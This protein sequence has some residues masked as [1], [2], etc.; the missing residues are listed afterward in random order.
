MLKRFLLIASISAGLFQIAPAEEAPKLLLPLA[1][2]QAIAGFARSQDGQQLASAD[3]LGGVRVWNSAGQILQTFQ[4]GG[5]SDQPLLS[6]CSKNVLLVQSGQ[7]IVLCNSRSGNV[8]KRFSITGPAVQI[9]GD[10]LWAIDSEGVKCWNVHDGKQVLE[11][12]ASSLGEKRRLKALACDPRSHRVAV[13]GESK[14]YFL[15][16]ATAR[17]VQTLDIP[18]EFAD[19]NWSYDVTRLLFAQNGEGM[20][21]GCE[22][23]WIL[24]RRGDRWKQIQLPAEARIRDLTADGLCLSD[25]GALYR[26]NQENASLAKLSQDSQWSKVGGE[27]D[28]SFYAGKFG[29]AIEQIG[30]DSRTSLPGDQVD[31]AFCLGLQGSEHLVL[32]TAGGHLVT[33]NLRTG[34]KEGAIKQGQGRAIRSLATSQNLLAAACNGKDDS[35]RVIGIY[36]R[37]QKLLRTVVFSTSKTGETT[38]RLEFSPDEHTLA[39]LDTFG[40]LALIDVKQGKVVETVSE[41]QHFAFSPDSRWLAI[42]NR[43]GLEERPWNGK[44]TNSSLAVR[45]KLPDSRVPKEIAYDRAGHLTFLSDPS[46]NYV[47]EQRGGQALPGKPIKRGENTHF[48]W[49]QNQWT[50]GPGI[51]LKPDL[52]GRVDHE[53][54][55]QFINPNSGSPLGR[56]LSLKQGT[57]WLVTSPQGLFDGTEDA[58][59]LVQWQ[60]GTQHFRVDQFFETGYRPGLLH[61]IWSDNR[62]GGKTGPLSGQVAPPD[63]EIL[64][65]A[66]GSSVSAAELEVRLKITDRG[67]GVSRTKV[68]VNGHPLAVKQASAEPTVTVKLQPGLNE[69]RA[70]AFDGQGTVESVGDSLRLH[71][72]SVAPRPAKLFLVCVGVNEAN[73]LGKLRYAQADASALARAFQTKLFQSCA[74]CL[75]TGEKATR[76]NVLSSLR[77]FQ[78]QAQTQDTLILFLAG[79]GRTDSRGYQYFLSGGEFLSSLDLAEALEQFPAQKQLLILDTCHSA[80]AVPDVAARFAISQQKMAR[81][82]GLFLL[83]ACR[84]QE[85]ATEAEA[86]R[87]GLLTYAL[88]E[89][90]KGKLHSFERS[91]P[92]TV[93]A[94]LQYASLQTALLSERFRADQEVYQYSNGSDFPIMLPGPA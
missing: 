31:M 56:L 39:V 54:T 29:G 59:R 42:S 77:E 73:R 88:L 10:Q 26:L 90:F 78:A 7:E 66:P 13:A 55:L 53:G 72:L 20:I 87:H 62:G 47:Y 3:Q 91:Q 74:K 2:H 21:A 14:I 70:S 5:H 83:A 12:A 23:G 86:L 35:Q 89:G 4:L 75:L 60:V 6:W 45:A 79:H 37:A 67:M 9:L 61:Q 93:N 94:L 22:R 43:K 82:S 1:H 64:S 15:D 36:D 28:G 85:S 25:Q 76:Q 34:K 41:C 46:A 18:K 16:D 40:Q 19:K 71:C 17:V 30:K 50:S 8:V 38:A 68:Y 33:F 58:Q 24:V 52:Y 69:I 48:S 92:I 80:A 11:I 63:I 81:G 84:P 57:Q 51:E 44:H 27:M 49:A 32:G 65:P